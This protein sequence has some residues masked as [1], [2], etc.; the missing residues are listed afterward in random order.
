MS[1][2]TVRLTPQE[3]LARLSRMA[4]EVRAQLAAHAENR[5][6]VGEALPAGVEDSLKH[7]S[8]SLRILSESVESMDQERRNLRALADVA[9]V[10]NSSL[11]LA[12]VLNEVI[13]TV[14]RLT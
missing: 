8:S 12:T 10:V 14:I 2:P 11:D 9:K 7:L 1:E 13:D 4:D 5:R 6:R 3:H